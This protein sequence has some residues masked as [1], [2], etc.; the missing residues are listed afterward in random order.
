MCNAEH[1]EGFTEMKKVLL[2]VNA[3]AGITQMAYKTYDVIETLAR[4]GYEVTVYP[5]LPAEG[6]IS[7]EEYSE[8]DRIFASKYGLDLSVL[9]R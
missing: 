8:I 1:R 3:S 9:F 7:E 2:L 5:V 4:G 6:L